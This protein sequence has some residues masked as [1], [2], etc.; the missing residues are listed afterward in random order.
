MGKKTTIETMTKKIDHQTD[1]FKLF[2]F[3]R[4]KAAIWY[5]KPYWGIDGGTIPN[6][7]NERMSWMR[8]FIKKEIE[9]HQGEFFKILEIG[10]WLGSSA[11]VWADA[12]TKYNNGNGLVVCVD[13]WAPYVESENLG[14]NNT[15][16]IMNEALKKDKI[17]PLFLNNIRSFGME[18]IIKPYR[19]KS[20]EVLPTLREKCFNFVYVD[21]SHFYTQVIKDLN[22]CHCLVS[23]NGVIGGDDLELQ[24]DEVNAENAMKQQEKDYITDTKKNKNFHPGVT[25]AVG[26]F[27][28]QRVS[29]YEG[30]WIMRKKQSDWHQIDLAS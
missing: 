3:L 29:S 14:I 26:E 19:G 12:I 1:K 28:K 24:I 8:K 21:G 20:D 23:E 13:P 30:F 11:I 5:N 6:S 18:N 27:F 16:Y 25:V 17:F 7:S 22:L 4:Y 9:N 15:P 10:S 2:D